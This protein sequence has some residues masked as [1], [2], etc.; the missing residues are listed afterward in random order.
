MKELRISSLSSSQ[1]NDQQN[2]LFFH[3]RDVVKPDQRDLSPLRKQ[4]CNLWAL[5]T[6]TF[7]TRPTHEGKVGERR[8]NAGRRKEGSAKTEG[9]SRR[10]VES[11]RHRATSTDGGFLLLC[12]SRTG[13]TGR[14]SEHGGGRRPSGLSLRVVTPGATGSCTVKRH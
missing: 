5:F 10:R 1:S 14:E 8:E 9:L 4:S 11:P 7:S 2:R 3:Q 13:E 6:S 12:K